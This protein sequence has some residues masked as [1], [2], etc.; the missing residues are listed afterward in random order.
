[1]SDRSFGEFIGG[2]V[3]WTA[4]ISNLPQ[5]AKGIFSFAGKFLVWFIILGFVGYFVQVFS[6]GPVVGPVAPTDVRVSARGT[7]DNLDVTAWNP[8]TYKITM[9]ELNC[10]GEN[11]MIR[12]IE[13]GDSANYNTFAGNIMRGPIECEVLKIK[14]K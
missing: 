8:T 13:A 6:G 10:G 9:L 5:I 4:V 7:L 14:S 2:G 1:M 3:F 11:V 12:D